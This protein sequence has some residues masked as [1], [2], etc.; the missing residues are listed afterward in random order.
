MK[1]VLLV[2]DNPDHAELFRRSFATHDRSFRLIV[3]GD[4]AAARQRLAGDPP[5]LVISD[6]ILSDG[7][8]TELLAEGLS[9]RVP[10]VILTSQGNE[11]VAVDALKQG[12]IDYVVKPS[13]TFDDLPRVAERALREWDQRREQRR[14]EEQLEHFFQT[15]DSLLCVIT[16]EGMCLRVNPA[17]E[18]RL[19]WPA[20]QL[21]GRCLWDFVHPDDA[22]LK[23]RLRDE[24][25]AGRQVMHDRVRMVDRNDDVHW[26]EWLITP[27]GAD[28]L[29]YATALDITEQVHRQERE[30]SRKLAAAKLSVLTQRERQVLQLVVDGEP[31]KAIAARLELNEKTVEKHRSRLMRKLKCRSLAAL[32]RF[33]V[34]AQES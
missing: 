10:V 11:T 26:L 7:R 20:D 17:T 23:G 18:R 13:N 14:L 12:A 28:A 27:A 21:H 9:Q 30:E 3:A 24:L 33:V 19:G 25:V 16:L 31:N 2:E 8:A 34:S 6:L 1:T 32:V 5:D 22:E 29:A 15:A 4:L